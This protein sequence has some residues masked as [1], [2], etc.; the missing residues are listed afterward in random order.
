MRPVVSGSPHIEKTKG[1]AFIG[2]HWL[3]YWT[4]KFE[5]PRDLGKKI[6]ITYQKFSAKIT[7]LVPQR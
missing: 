2:N 3:S 6:R 4:L 7:T 5:F 1:K